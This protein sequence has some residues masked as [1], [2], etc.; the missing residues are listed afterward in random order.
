MKIYSINLKKGPK[1]KNFKKTKILFLIPVVSFSIIIIILFSLKRRSLDK[2][3]SSQKYKE[4]EL[5]L[6]SKMSRVSK[7]FFKK[8]QEIIESI[9][10]GGD[11]TAKY[12][13]KLAQKSNQELK[14][15]VVLKTLKEEIFK[16]ENLDFYI[17]YPSD[18]N[19]KTLKILIFNQGI[20]SLIPPSL[21][22]PL[23]YDV[24][25][26]NKIPKEKDYIFI[27]GN[28]PNH[29]RSIYNNNDFVILN[30]LV[31]KLKERFALSEK[32]TFFS[33]SAGAYFSLYYTSAYPEKVEEIF[34]FAPGINLSDFGSWNIKRAFSGKKVRIW[35]G[36]KDKNIKYEISKD[37][38]DTLIKNDIDCKFY[39]VSDKNHFDKL[40]ELEEVLA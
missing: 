36:E 16:F 14:N 13:S 10:I 38:C 9:K 24:L 1:N 17:S 5:S 35:H 25:W 26:Y 4:N 19:N 11:I 7:K 30:R 31:E 8:H 40:A 27:S 22:S 37:F 18:F 2:N 28:F 21:E 32:I 23:P 12:G 39:L 34:L 15:Q 20:L 3:V 6:F 29:S 33:Y